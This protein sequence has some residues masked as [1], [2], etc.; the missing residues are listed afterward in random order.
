MPY[1]IKSLTII[2]TLFAFT[3]EGS[4]DPGQNDYSNPYVK[5]TNIIHLKQ[6]ILQG[7]VVEPKL[8]RNVR[9]QVGVF[10]GIPYAAPPVGDLRFM[11]TR[12]APSWFDV[13]VADTFG[14]VC[15]QKFPDEKTMSPYR[16][17]YFLRL[18]QY[19]MNQSEDCLYLNI[20][21]PISEDETNT[22]KYPVMVFIHGESFEWNSGNPY[23]GSTLAAY[24][25]VIVVTINFRLGVLGF[26]KA[27]TE[28]QSQSNFGLVDQIAALVWIKDNIAAFRGDI[29]SI[30]L[31]GHG[32]GAA[33]VSLLMISPMILK[34]NERLFHRAILMG[35]TALADWAL[36]NNSAQVTYQVAMALNCQIHDDFAKCLRRKRLD[37]IM[38]ADVITPDYKTRFG[39]VVDS[40]VVPS[41]PEKSMTQ[42]NDLFRRFEL[43]YGVTELESVHLLGPVALTQGL[44]EKERDQQLRAYFY[45]RCEVKPELCLQRTLDE[46]GQ[47]ELPQRDSAGGF[48]GDEPDRASLARNALLDILSDARSVAPVVQTGRYH[49]ALNL[50]SY[51][52]VFTHRTQSKEYIRDKS[53]NGEELPYVFGVPL[54]GP[55]HH[56]SDSYTEQ[57]QMFSEIVMMY[58]SNFAE[59]GNPNVPKRQYFYSMNPAYWLQFDVEWPE[60]D[61]EEEWYLNL[62][63]PPQPSQHYRDSKIR[64]WN[65]IFPKLTENFSFPIYPSTRPTAETPDFLK[66][67]RKTA[68]PFLYDHLPNM[69]IAPSNDKYM[70]FHKPTRGMSRAVFGTVIKSGERKPDNM[71]KNVYG[72]I[73]ESTPEEV[74]QATTM[75]IVTIVGAVF[76]MVNLLLLVTLYF[77]CY[78][79][80][81]VSSRTGHTTNTN[82]DEKSRRDDENVLINGCNIMKMMGKSTRSDD[83]YEAVKNDPRYKLHR[84]MSGSTIDAHTKVRQ[85]IAQEIIQKYSP[86]FFRRPAQDDSNSKSKQ[87]MPEDFNVSIKVEGDSTLGRSPTRP[88]SPCEEKAIPMRTSTITR[89]K[90]K[91]P[92][93]SVA[94]DATPS[95]RGNSVLMQKPIELTKSLD[96]PNTTPDMDT[97]LRRS[98][99]MEDFSPRVVDFQN[100]LRKSATNVSCHK[101][102]FQPTIIKIEHSHSKSDPVQDLD[103]TAMRRLKTF[104][105]NGDIN[106]TCRDENEQTVPLSPEES[107]NIIKRRNFPKVLPDHPGRENLV[108]KRR[109]MPIPGFF[110]PIPEGSSFSQN[111]SSMPKSLNKFPPVPPPRSST[112]M[113]Q[114][115]NPLPVFISEPTLAEEPE[116]EPEI[117]CN[118]LYVGPLI[119]KRRDGH[120]VYGS[121]K[122]M[123]GGSLGKVKHGG[124]IKH[125]TLS[126]EMD[127]D[128]FIRMNS[129][130][131][132]QNVIEVC[133]EQEKTE[134][135]VH[136]ELCDVNAKHR[137]VKKSQ[138]PTL[139]KTPSASFNKESSSSDSTP[140]E[141]SDTG[142]VVKRI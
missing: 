64:Y 31:F 19:L 65:E 123:I 97:P 40:I 45:S 138:I 83:T 126:R 72:T 89:P 108:N 96:Y 120:Q 73:L 128:K 46:Y 12:G 133:S 10:K 44:L 95:G 20:Y 36:A 67:P 136:H 33:C 60:F 47:S 115:S 5:Y 76:L 92:K 125:P 74:K 87:T 93:V 70:N 75:N 90:M 132:H 135:G 127:D 56:F 53:Y 8:G 81:K 121:L 129:K 16:K 24:G 107:L 35:G 9:K 57:E 78:R 130:L 7:T 104:D 21:T 32:T 100:D 43:I 11:Y 101:S 59:T 114:S 110:M 49:A 55:K 13:K 58:F 98:F 94:V 42:Y 30:T 122:N 82:G 111:N 119:P 39:P 63:I 1:I 116:E 41:E 140:S 52:Y 25:N 117:V 54:G 139:V 66:S 71:V 103:Y 84:Q 28:T 137:V 91:V 2:M 85:W 109:S 34:E 38:A 124:Q 142:T 51:F 80:K 26:L 118:N 79:N 141:E 27:G 69:A 106:V 17:E 4:S 62:G 113:K 6:G 134:L 23:D 48:T 61:I 112:L 77:K 88:V 102:N 131:M 105:P 68:P 22:R 37:E 99:T 18:K 29:N 14:P 15:P 86:R 50:Q 3:L